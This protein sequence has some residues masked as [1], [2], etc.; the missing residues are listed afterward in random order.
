MKFI[1]KDES[2]MNE[3]IEIIKFLK[4][5]TQYTTMMC[6]SEKIHIQV[7][8]DSHIS[9]LDIHIPSE[10]FESYHC[11]IPMT[12][13]V[14]NSILTKLLNLY[15]KGSIMET[16]IDDEKY[17]LS[18]LNEQENK[19]FCIGLV[20]IE[21][22]LLAPVINDTDLDFSLKTSLLDTYLNDLSIF[23]DDLEIKYNNDKLYFITTGDE[24]QNKIEIS[25]DSC[26]DF[27]VVD[28]YEF[29]CKYSAKYLHYISKLKKNYKY[30]HLYLDENNPLHITFDNDTG[31]KIDYFIAPKIMDD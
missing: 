15:S 26:I 3:Y 24:G 6:T 27:S 17:N 2:K 9:L 5:L 22:E 12:F 21:K 8:D 14:N 31:I 11:E 23:G 4:N 29:Q 18:Y 1:I 7:L 25:Y 13:S 16:E 28:D 10:W 20:D 19:Y 30:I